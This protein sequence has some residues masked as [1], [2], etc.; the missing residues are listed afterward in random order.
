MFKEYQ[1]TKY[2]TG[3]KKQTVNDLSFKHTL[4]TMNNTYFIGVLVMKATLLS[5]V[6]CLLRRKKEREVRVE[7]KGVRVRVCV[8]VCVCSPDVFVCA[9]LTVNTV[10]KSQGSHARQETATSHQ[11]E[12]TLK[13]RCRERSFESTIGSPNEVR[14]SPSSCMAHRVFQY[15]TVHSATANS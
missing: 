4:H 2:A 9:W 14:A 1:L 13:S 11:K 6:Q 5:K 15:Y 8:C 10:E 3:R 7:G 12:T